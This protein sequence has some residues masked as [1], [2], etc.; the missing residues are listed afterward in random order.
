MPGMVKEH[1][2]ESIEGVSVLKDFRGGQCRLAC[3]CPDCNMTFSTVVGDRLPPGAEEFARDVFVRLA[4]RN[5]DRY[6][7]WE[8]IKHRFE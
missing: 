6:R 5:T 7:T 8:R 4:D 1:V 3:F 2:F